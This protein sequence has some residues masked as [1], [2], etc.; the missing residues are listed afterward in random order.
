MKEKID[1]LRLLFA[2]VL[3]SILVATCAGCSIE[4][5]AQKKTAWL[6]AHDKLDDVC[7]RI[8]PPIESITVRRDTVKAGNID[9]T[10]LLDSLYK[11][12]NDSAN[13][14]WTLVVDSATTNVADVLQQRLSLAKKEIAGLKEVIAKLRKDY[15]PCN[16]DIIF[17]DTTRTVTNTAEVDRLKGELLK[18]DEQVKAKDD[19]I[20]QQ[21]KKIDS[22][23]K[24][25]LLFF[26]LLGVNVIG[27]IIRF[28]VIK[29]PI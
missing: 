18:K 12:V 28:F 13:E 7:A 17:I 29:K 16:P 8:Y 27:F 23:D 26:L 9:Y 3:A 6:M 2:V 4:K 14:S 10:A 22:Q 5:Q 15:K 11:V 21:Q 24:W 1:P 20:I 19:I 25:K